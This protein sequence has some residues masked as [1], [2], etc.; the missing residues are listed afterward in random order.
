MLQYYF[1]I[2]FKRLSK[3]SSDKSSLYPS[4][5]NFEGSVYNQDVNSPWQPPKKESCD[6]INLIFKDF[7]KAG[8]T[9]LY[10][11]DFVLGSTF[12]YKMNGFD[13]PPTDWYP[14]PFWIAAH[15]MTTN[16]GVPPCVC[17]DQELI[18]FLKTFTKDC[19]QE[20]KFSF[21][22]SSNAHDN[23]NWLIHLEDDLIGK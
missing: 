6:T 10:N 16:C 19:E 23:M 5:P 13:K 17:E 14:R 22:V 7:M 3:L 18:R 15:E 4:L 20:K 1:I 8:Y 21:Q 2:F 9:T 12:T 11:E